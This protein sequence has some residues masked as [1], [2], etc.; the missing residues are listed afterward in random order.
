MLV[1][2]LDVLIRHFTTFYRTCP[3]QP[4]TIQC[5]R[6]N[7]RQYTIMAAF[8]LGLVAVGASMMIYG[9][10]MMYKQNQEEEE[11]AQG[12]QGAEADP[13][14]AEEGKVATEEA[15]AEADGDNKDDAKKAGGETFDLE[16][17]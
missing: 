5:A 10:R 2:V 14:A 4:T 9:G 8:G 6:F 15:G 3:L 12:D 11:G 17:S 1:D 16:I 7:P 13:V